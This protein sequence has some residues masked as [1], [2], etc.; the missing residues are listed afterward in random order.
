MNTRGKSKIGISTPNELTN[1]SFY[2]FYNLRKHLGSGGYGMVWA[3]EEKRR[4]GKMNAV[5]IISEAKCKRKTYCP[6][7]DCEVPDE[8]ALWMPLSHP[9]ILSLNDVFYESFSRHWYLVTDYDPEAHDLFH[10]VDVN[11]P[12]NSRDSAHIISQIIEAAYYLTQQGVDHRDIKDENILY[13]PRTKQIKLIDFGSA[14]IL[15]TDSYRTYQGTDVYLPP[16][17]YQFKCYDPFPACVW[18]IGCLAYVLFNGDCPFETKK[19]VQEF[20]T[21]RWKVDKTSLNKQGVKFVEMCLEADPNRR[22]ELGSLIHHPWL[23]MY[24]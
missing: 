13:N 17:Y 15:T 22:L 5:K 1:E 23:K 10:F 14:S 12:L 18:S 7:R 2:A 3:C 9:L 19:D 8:V 16:E 4:P 24:S 11:G 20:T 21:L 6:T